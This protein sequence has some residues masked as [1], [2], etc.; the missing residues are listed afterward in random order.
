MQRR[1]VPTDEHSQVLRCASTGK[2]KKRQPNG[3]RSMDVCSL[4]G[5]ASVFSE[6]QDNKQT[7]TL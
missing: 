2:R 7:I 3:G 4:G 1:G 5:P 6:R